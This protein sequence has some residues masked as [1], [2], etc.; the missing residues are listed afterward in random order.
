MASAAAGGAAGAAGLGQ[1]QDD[2]V[3]AWAVDEVEKAVVETLDNT[4]Q[5]VVYQD[6]QVGGFSFF[7]A[8]T[9]ETTWVIQ[10]KMQFFQVPHWVNSI[11]EDVMKRLNDGKKP[12]KYIVTC[13]IAQRNGAGIHT[14]NACYWDTVND[15][16]L[17]YVWPKEKS[18]DQV[19]KTVQAIVTVFALDYSL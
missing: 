19:N 1:E 3:V 18:K 13:L 7:G 15:G 9:Y 2:T 12:F 17:T 14:S 6:E 11:C 16:I 5:D 10:M 4:L 8:D